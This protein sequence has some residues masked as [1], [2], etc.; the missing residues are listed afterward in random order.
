MIINKKAKFDYLFLDEYIAGIMLKGSEMKPLENGEANLRDSFCYFKN[1][2][3]FTNFH[4]SENKNSKHNQHDPIRPKKL[5]LTKRQLKKIKKKLE[6]KG[7]TIIPYKLFFNKTGLV[8]IIIKIGKGKR[9]FD[10]RLSLK[11]AD[12]KREIKN[13]Y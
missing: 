10:K 9:K 4:I 1:N 13:E 6:E 12:L 11:E 8:K 7:L 3:L 5:L 2:E